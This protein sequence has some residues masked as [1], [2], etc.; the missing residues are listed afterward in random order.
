MLR[1]PPPSGG[2]SG[3]ASLDELVVKGETRAVDDAEFEELFK[4]TKAKFCSSPAWRQKRLL[5]EVSA[6]PPFAWKFPHGVAKSSAIDAEHCDWSAM[7]G[8]EH[9]DAGSEGVTF[10]LL[11]DD[12]AVVVKAG[13]VVAAELFGALIAAHLGVRHPKA[14]LVMRDSDEGIAIRHN[15]LAFDSR[16]EHPS[17]AS[18]MLKNPFY[19][20][21]EYVKGTELEDL[22][23]SR[24]DLTPD[25]NPFCQEVFG[26]PMG[27]PAEGGGDDHDGGLITEKG[28]DICR[29]LGKM[30]AFDF[31][32][33][34][35]DRLPCIW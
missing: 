9:S 21:M 19:L 7:Q 10:V 23:H 6:I 35:W 13:C 27:T 34:N 5:S 28:K 29:D 16:R 20:V 18:R 2:T 15:L 4:M 25:M 17:R 8:M 33:N 30:I 26:D 12:R 32:L 14:R 11:P 1:P 31:L 24:P 22:Y 3:P